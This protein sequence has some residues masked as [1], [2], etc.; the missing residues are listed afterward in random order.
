MAT[1]TRS[2][3]VSTPKNHLNT[4]PSRSN[5]SPRTTMGAIGGKTIPGKSPAVK[6][7][8]SMQSHV[9]KMSISSHPTSTPLAPSAED[10]LALNMNMNTPAALLASLGSGTTG[11]TPLPPSSVEGL[12]ITTGTTTA[13]ATNHHLLTSQTD[14]TSLSRNPERE[15]HDRLKEVA[16]I[17]R[18]RTAGRGITREH[19]EKLASINRFDTGF[20][21][22]QLS[23]AGQRRVDLEITFDGQPDHRDTVKKVA[24]KLNLPESDDAIYQEDASKV[25]TANL[26]Q[27]SKHTRDKQDDDVLPWQNLTDFSTNL[28]Y[29]SRLEHVDTAANCFQ[30][31]DSLYESFQRIWNEEK[32]RVKWRSDSHHL[33]QGNIGR[34]V[35]DINGRLGVSTQFWSKGSKFYKKQ[36]SGSVAD[37]R[38]GTDTDDDWTATFSIESG[39]PAMS[40]TQNWLAEDILT[41]TVRAED[42]FQESATDKPAW[43]DPS[44]T[45]E[46]TQ[47][48]DMSMDVNRPATETQGMINMHFTCDLRSKIYI[49]LQVATSMNGQVQM[50]ELRNDRVSTFQHIVFGTRTNPERSARTV[51]TAN[52]EGPSQSQDHSYMLYATGQSWIHPIRKL[53]FSHPKQFAQALP[54]LRQYAL[55]NTLL[56]S[57]KQTDEIKRPDLDAVVNLSQPQAPR[58]IPVRGKVTKR[59]NKVQLG[60]N[61]ESI[62][63]PSI[64]ND[65]PLMVDVRI[66]SATSQIK[67]CRLELR[68]PVTAKL[69]P[70]HLLPSGKSSTFLLIQFDV[71]LNGIVEV[72]GFEGLLIER[73][74]L[75]GLRKRLAKVV[76]ASEDIGI[77]VEWVLQ[78][79]RN[80]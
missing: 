9:H 22:D 55:V 32:N 20:D 61:L 35:K 15:R 44:S 6:T 71:L 52:K 3:V 63:K 17:F 57:L 1:P 77:I 4:T 74:K 34:P 49:P 29:L 26:T 76:R 12:N 2:Q 78:Q 50:V 51:Y 25:L 80:L 41:S 59:S 21:E 39:L 72:I 40:T 16:E 48:N 31:M 70:P 42:I 5:A 14:L 79:L 11:L 37:D 68:I 58:A 8:A 33:C 67:S 64:R 54:M 46:N 36:D 60:A 62:L 19:I 66:D 69:L 75:D 24:L 18:S 30:V 65:S 73:S 38:E 45:K 7:P 28:G 56:Q 23:I 53:S 10:I 27:D 43:Q 13:S 47:D